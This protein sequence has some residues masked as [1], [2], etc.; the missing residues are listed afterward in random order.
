MICGPCLAGDQVAWASGEARR[1]GAR[2]HLET[3]VTSERLTPGHRIRTSGYAVVIA[4]WDE[5]DPA[6]DD[7]ARL[8][9]SNEARRVAAAIIAAADF[10]DG[11][12]SPNKDGSNPRTTSMK[13]G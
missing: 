7:G 13:E 2:R 4:R 3:L 8:L 1:E 5:V 10:V 11:L 9:F 12:A 6:D